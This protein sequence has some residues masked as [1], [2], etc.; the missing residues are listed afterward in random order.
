MLLQLVL[1]DHPIHTEM[2]DQDDLDALLSERLPILDEAFADEDVAL[3]DRPLRC[4]LF[5]AQKCAEK[6]AGALGAN[7]RFESPLFRQI[8]NRVNAWYDWKYKPG[9]FSPG[10]HKFRTVVLIHGT[11]FE[12]VVP[13]TYG[14]VEE[15]GKTAWLCFPTGVNPTERVLGWIKNAPNFDS[16]SEAEVKEIT[17]SIEALVATIRGANHDLQ[18]ANRDNEV[19]ASFVETVEAHLVKAVDDILTLEPARLKHS[20]WEMHLA[21]EKSIKGLLCSY[22]FVPKKI[23][24]LAELRKQAETVVHSLNIGVVDQLQNWKVSLGNR[25]G[26]GASV[27][28]KQA[29]NNLHSATRVV[30]L[31]ASQMKR[32]VSFRNV[33]I[34]LRLPPWAR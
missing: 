13:L 29:V 23:H 34:L 30:A 19:D 11:A 26:E 28:G 20:N 1:E 8:C 15:E 6:D 7:H 10:Q 33:E 24:D 17:I 21:V 25:Y 18:T 31:V 14:R 22:G 4:A 5:I 2:N 9:S 12:L 27:S 3:S 32:S 16:C